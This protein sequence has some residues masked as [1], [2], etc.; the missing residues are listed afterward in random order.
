MLLLEIIQSYFPAPSYEF[1]GTSTQKTG[2]V[3]NQ[4]V[5]ENTTSETQQTQKD[6]EN[7][8]ETATV[9]IKSASD[10][11]S[12][13]IRICKFYYE[14]S[15]FVFFQGAKLYTKEL[16]SSK[17]VSTRK[18]T[19][20]PENFFVFYKKKLQWLL[21]LH[22]F[23]FVNSILL[24]QNLSLIEYL[25]SALLL[26][27]LQF[28]IFSLLTRLLS[29]DLDSFLLKKLLPFSG[30]KKDGSS[31]KYLELA[32][33][34]SSFPWIFL[35]IPNILIKELGLHWIF[36]LLSFLAILLWSFSLF[37]EISYP[38]YAKHISIRSFRKSFIQSYFYLLR[39][40]FVFSL[41]IFVYFSFIG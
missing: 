32:C 24:Y 25:V 16:R 27:L 12:L 33:I 1:K 19:N 13:F 11:S 26:T 5:V 17:D 7:K 3:E 29:S 37:L 10:P 35:I 22:S 2:E 31:S 30:T 18:K 40:P 8:A 6:V 14:L 38:L 41:S 36:T 4:K 21:V 34:L 28:Y 20:S 15:N 39:F 9:P 23:C